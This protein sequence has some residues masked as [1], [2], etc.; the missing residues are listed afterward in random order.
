MSEHVVDDCELPAL[1]TITQSCLWSGVVTVS[2]PAHQPSF[3]LSLSISNNPTYFSPRNGPLWLS[4]MRSHRKASESSH[5][6]PC[7]QSHQ[8]KQAGR[9]P[10]NLVPFFDFLTRCRNGH[11]GKC[12]PPT[13]KTMLWTP[14]EWQ[15]AKLQWTLGKRQPSPIDGGSFTQLL[16]ADVGKSKCRENETRP[17]SFSRET[18]IMYCVWNI[19]IFSVCFSS[20]IE[21]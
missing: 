6:C 18:K 5:M 3:L 1:P 20:F 11:R 14:W 8:T 16:L 2:T 19:P 17:L 13:G 15:M 9:V 21:V 12:F 10:L 7:P 4:T